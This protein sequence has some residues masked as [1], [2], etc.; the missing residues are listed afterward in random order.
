M[1]T[2]TAKMRQ[3]CDEKSP[4]C[5]KFAKKARTDLID[6][7]SGFGVV[8]DG[9]FAAFAA[10]ADIDEEVGAEAPFRVVRTHVLDRGPAIDQGV[11]VEVFGRKSPN[12]FDLSVFGGFV[13]G[14]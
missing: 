10:S 12:L 2:K 5:S 13:P 6:N 4:K 1:Q 7:E 8:A 11:G 3:R 9:T 14:S